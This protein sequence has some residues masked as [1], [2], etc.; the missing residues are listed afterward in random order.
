M[1]SDI[2]YILL[3]KRYDVKE[4]HNNNNNNNNTSKNYYYNIVL[5]MN[6]TKIRLFHLFIT[7]RA[8]AFAFAGPAKK[9]KVNQ[10]RTES[11]D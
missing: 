6:E 11:R 1:V 4:K 10:S 7:F 2:F 3:L 5:L 8:L 9:F